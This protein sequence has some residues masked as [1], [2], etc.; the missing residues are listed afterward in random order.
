MEFLLQ[1]NV[2]STGSTTNLLNS[3]YTSYARMFAQMAMQRTK[4]AA[5]N[6]SLVFA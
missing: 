3:F 5:M 4:T 1:P 6:P 2:Y